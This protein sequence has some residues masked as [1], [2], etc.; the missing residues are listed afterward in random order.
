MLWNWKGLRVGVVSVLTLDLCTLNLQLM[1]H[2]VLSWASSLLTLHIVYFFGRI[3]LNISSVQLW[4]SVRIWHMLTLPLIVWR[5]SSSRSLLL[6]C[7]LPYWGCDFLL[8]SL[9]FL[10]FWELNKLVAGEAYLLLKTRFNCSN[11]FLI[12]I[13]VDESLDYLKEIAKLPLH[14]G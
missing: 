3:F 8:S 10:N 7:L 1:G 5:K 11:N 9:Q 14:L 4:V 2:V 12:F 6:R 13:I